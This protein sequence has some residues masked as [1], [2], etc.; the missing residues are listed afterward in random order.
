MFQEIIKNWR[1]FAL[2]AL[3]S[4]SMAMCL[5]GCGDESVVDGN[6]DGG[7]YE[8]GDENLTIVDFM[9]NV[10]DT[11][12]ADYS[13]T[14][15]GWLVD[16]TGEGANYV[17]VY[18][19]CVPTNAGYFYKAIDTTRVDGSFSTS[20]VPVDSGD[21]AVWVQVSGNA[22]NQTSKNI[23]V[24]P[25]TS[26]GGGGGDDPDQTAYDF[27]FQVPE[28]FI[29]ADGQ[30]DVDI[31]LTINP[32]SKGETVET[33]TVVRLEAGERFVD[34]N[35]DGYFTENVDEVE[36]DGN[37]NGIWDR[38][39]SVPSAVTTVD[40]VA[41]F[42]YTSGTQS[43]LV[44]IRATIGDP[45]DAAY[46]EVALALRPS[47]EVAYIELHSARTDIQVKGTGGIES[48]LLYAS[49]Y[50]RYGNPTQMGVAVDFNILSGPGGGESIELQ[51]YGPVTAVTNVQ[52][53][54]AVSLLSG[55]VS[56]TIKTQSS[57]ASTYSNVTLIDVN[58]GPPD[59][60]SL[61]VGQCNLPAWNQINMTNSV[62]A[63]VEDMYDNPVMDSIVV[64]FTT[65]EIGMIEASSVTI[66]GIATSTFRS[67]DDLLDGRA[68]I[69]AE[70]EG[71]EVIDSVHFWVTGPPTSVD[72][73]SYPT[74]LAADGKSYGDVYVEVLDLNS[75]FVVDGTEVEFD[76][77]P[78]GTIENSA[79]SNGCYFSVAKSRLTSAVLSKDYSYSIPD[80]GIGANGLLTATAGEGA[81]IS[82]SVIVQLTTGYTYT[83]NSEFEMETSVAPGSSEPITMV[84]KDR[85]GNPL[86]GHLITGEASD[87]FIT[88][89]D[90]NTADVDSLYSNDHGEVVGF[91]YVAPAIEGNAFITM[92]DHDP[93]GGVIWTQK[94]T[95]KAAS[96]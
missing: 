68:V 39:G 82:A 66:D 62:V 7:G 57:V 47:S 27:Q 48:T 33:G 32:G 4:I 41:S 75:N 72:I 92:T 78:E 79:T 93:R 14:V 3:V 6:G 83:E 44:F 77:W 2:I 54:A 95:L 13:L 5:P 20:F 61:G 67:T 55:T 18:F 25:R 26:G 70:T 21:V 9:D 80:D 53:V 28:G 31:V 1:K 24:L 49:C 63:L 71:G 90:G 96:E 87:G 43:G 29:L 58:A 37:D 30:N 8:P 50:D 60:I 94:I 69:I 46:G 15:H 64:Y 85:A 76:F 52:G 88:I 59:N 17:P 56:G 40:N 84:I 16:S 10:A 89:N 86:G 19:Y 81:G 12:S 73:Y 51:G 74:T 34:V 35:G 36:Y 45:S 42:T 23:H 65:N 11:V 91:Q 38:I 22:V